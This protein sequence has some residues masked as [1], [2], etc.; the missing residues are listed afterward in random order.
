MSG[1]DHGE[2]P[3]D[4][5]LP[6]GSPGAQ[7][8]GKVAASGTLWVLASKWL[9]RLSGLVT[10]AVLARLIAP[11]D[12]GVV[13]A[14]ATIT[15]LALLLADLGL[16]TFVVQ[17]KR[18]DQRLLST[19]FWFS[20]LAGV[21]LWG[22][23]VLAAPFIAGAFDLPEAT[24]VLRVMSLSILLVV[25]QSVPVALMRRRM[26][27]KLLSVQDVI[28]TGVG[29]VLAIVLALN[30]AGA[31][32]LVGQMLSYQ[33]FAGCLAWRAARWCPSL[34]FSQPQFLAMGRFG[35]KVVSVDM[36]EAAR[37]AAEAAIIANALGAAALGFMS[38]AQRLI[39]VT[40]ELGAA[41]LVPVAVVVFAKVRDS[42]ERLRAGYLRALRVSYA[43]VSPILTLVAVTGPLLVTVIF[44]PGWEPSAPVSQGLAIAAILTLGA[45]LDNALFYGIGKPG[46]WAAYAAV[47]NLVTVGVTA[48]AAPHGLTAVAI[49]FV[50]VAFAATVARWFLVSRTLK[51]RTGPLAMIFARAGMAV[52]G[53][54]AIGVLVRNLTEFMPPVASVAAVAAAILT[55]HLGIIRLVSPEVLEDVIDVLPGWDKLA[56]RLR[57]R[58]SWS[59]G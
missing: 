50:F 28:S 27:F 2:G 6:S 9:A 53:S 30:G 38:L 48:L 40:Q 18:V 46:R 35:I 13:A 25:L 33:V 11:E 51:M 52:I 47:T 43:A 41:A 8:L 10:L 45:M 3:L 19:A 5:G 32:A 14:A 58:R 7:P 20:G 54:A 1:S 49:G 36:M 22:A 12:F 37:A 4:G 31:W 59:R 44:G 26:Q 24:P 21:A 55:T 17:A 15:P 16:S 56:E 23:L 57:R 34:D 39:R 42:A 29:Q